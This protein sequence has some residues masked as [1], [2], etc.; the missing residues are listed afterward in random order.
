MN[1]ITKTIPVPVTV[2]L[3]CELLPL[4]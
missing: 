2:G 4:G 1:E 3:W